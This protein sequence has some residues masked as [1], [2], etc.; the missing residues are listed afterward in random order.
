[1]LAVIQ[2]GFRIIADLPPTA[3]YQDVRPPV[4]G[5]DV[6]G[7]P[8]RC[9]QLSGFF[10]EQHGVATGDALHQC[11]FEGQGSLEQRGEA[12]RFSRL[13]D[14]AGAR[15]VQQGFFCRPAGDPGQSAL[16]FLGRPDVVLV[17]ECV[18]AG[19]D[20]CCPDQ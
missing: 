14:Q 12:D 20:A 9:E 7:F 15:A 17:T 5:N 18:I 2:R 8:G 16:E 10:V 19:L 13:V 3:G 1:M 4:M 6:A 11:I